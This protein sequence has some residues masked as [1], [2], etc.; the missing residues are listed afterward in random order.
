MHN[1]Y[2]KFIIGLNSTISLILLIISYH[3]NQASKVFLNLPSNDLAYIDDLDIRWF[4]KPYSQILLILAI[5]LIIFSIF[6]FIDN[7]KS[8]NKK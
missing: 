5:I 3:L 4:L 7:R 6:Y 8:S 2:T 1:K